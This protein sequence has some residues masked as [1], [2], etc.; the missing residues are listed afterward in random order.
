M[1]YE[2]PV[3]IDRLAAHYVHGSL[4]GA[5][6]LRFERLLA[7]NARVRQQVSVWEGRLAP[8]AYGLPPV[9]PPP[10]VRAALLAEI[11]RSRPLPLTSAPPIRPSRRAVY[12]RR[13]RFMAAA[14]ACGLLIVGGLIKMA[15]ARLSFPADSH[16]EVTELAQMAGI[17]EPQ[18][19]G[20]ELRPL[21]IMLAT[22]G[23]PGS[24]MSWM[25]SLSPD[26][27]QLS[28]TASDD[29]LNVGRSSVQLWWLGDNG[30]PQPL[31]ILGTERDSTVVVDV[32]QS[33][34]DGRALVFAISLEPPGGSP[35][36]QPTRPVLGRAGD[37]APAI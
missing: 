14:C 25:I 12:M 11:Q 26:H 9:A 19:S 7:A 31:A 18:L 28:I 27:R 21:P 6:R 34:S 13:L 17:A 2:H 15:G 29:M 36:G 10:G 33:L 30:Q 32:P 5:A 4:R 22:L 23:M 8:V 20:D 3:L 1:N 24:S 16:P 35:T 37:D